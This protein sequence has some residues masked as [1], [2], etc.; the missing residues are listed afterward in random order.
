MRQI[1][2]MGM[3]ALDPEIYGLSR[4]ELSRQRDGVEL[5][6][7]ENFVPRAVLEAQGSVLTNKYAEGYPHKKYYGGCEYAEAIEEIAI[8]RA[9]ELFGAEHA[10]VQPHCGSGANMAA[11]FAVMEPGDT[12]LA[13]SLDQGGH[14]THGHPLNFTGKMYDVVGYGVTRETETIDYDAMERLA[15]EHRPRVLV[16]GASAYPRI[17][18]FERF[19][20]IAREVGAVFLVD[21]AHIAG[22]VAGGAHPSP[23][24]HADFVTTTTHKTLRGPRGAL[25][26]CTA[27]YAKELDRSVFPGMQGGP[28]VHVIAAKA[29]CF[30][31]AMEPEFK[32]Y[33]AQVVANA[34]ALCRALADRGYRIV[35][36]G[37]D[38]HLVLVDC[39]ES[40]GVTGKDAERIL[41]ASGVTVNK[42]MIPF[43]QEKPLVTSGIRVGTAA[44]TTRGM[45]EPEM[46]RI[47]DA[48]DRVLSRPDDNEEHARVKAFVKELSAEFPLYPEFVEPWPTV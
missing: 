39:K 2:E 48:V 11:Y 33:V 38:N 47:A 18:D 44:V 4:S 26:L 28:L 25:A 34:K 13:M 37:T 35:S 36:G 9:K 22:L 14:L 32:V 12:L 19:S 16:A 29:V 5:I 20:R 23:V 8:N 41:N 3:K 31:L 10:N 42:N 43:D 1:L 27:Q 24:P 21:M 17:I 6:A 40:R 7:S 46:E 30:R 15:R 45:K